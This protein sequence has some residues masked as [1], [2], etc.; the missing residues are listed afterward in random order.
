MIYDYCVVGG[1]IVGLAVAYRLLEERSGA[2]VVVLEK[3]G[4]VGFHQTGHNSGVAHAGIYY[5][6]GSSKAR[7]CRRGRAALEAFC[8]EHGLPYE[9]RGKLVVA[10]NG[11]EKAALEDIRRRALA[12]NVAAELIG[13]EELEAR[14][15]GLRGLAALWV[16]DTGITDFKAVCGKLRELVEERGGSVHTGAPVEG[17]EERHDGVV[18][19]A[20]GASWRVKRVIA[21]AGLQADRVA[22]LAGLEPDFR[23]VP[24]RGEYFEVRHR[25]EVK[26]RHLVYPVPDPELPFLGV[27]LTP[28][29]DGRLLIGPNA[30]LAF[31]REG[32]GRWVVDVR[33]VAD[34]ALY[35]GFW[36]LLGR[37]RRH[38]VRE[39]WRAASRKAYVRACQR[40][41]RSIGLDDLGAYRCGVRAQAVR[42]DGT[43]F[44][45]FHFVRTARTLHVA[46]APS[47][48]ATSS[49]AI[50]EHVVAAVTRQEETM[51]GT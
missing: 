27:H 36:R 9:R 51:S 39:L 41:H 16:P 1:G 23:I 24:F 42:R 4:S 2:G 7:L 21:C 49:F 34:Y 37:H 43:A 5:A 12:N 25:E 47:P 20:G 35:P 11:R 31:A 44:E 46:N 33:D 18:V 26:V 6:P 32:Y 8:R 38:I 40:Y 22:R 13:Q 50:A 17:I 15:P 30:V 19:G 45:D 3:E 29:V 14:E 48:A 10:T 28:T